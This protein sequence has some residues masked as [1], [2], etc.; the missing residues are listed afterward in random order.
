[1]NLI[2]LLA[3]L[4]QDTTQLDR[5]EAMLCE[6]REAITGKAC[7][8]QPAPP[9]TGVPF[10]ERCAADGVIYCEPFE[11]DT[12][13]FWYEADGTRH[14]WSNPGIPAEI[15]W[16]RKSR[17][18][19]CKWCDRDPLIGPDGTEY[20]AVPPTADPDVVASEESTASLRMTYQPMA[21]Q[22]GAGAYFSE[23]SEDL[24]QVIAPM[25]ERSVAERQEFRE[26]HPEL[27]LVEPRSDRYFMQYRIRFSRGFIYDEDGHRIT[28]LQENGKPTS[29]K[30]AIALSTGSWGAGRGG[31]DFGITHPRDWG[32]DPGSFPFRN[33]SICTMH[34]I[35]GNVTWNWV[36][37]YY[38]S[39]KSFSGMR[40][41]EDYDVGGSA[42]LNYQ[43]RVEGGALRFPDPSIKRQMDQDFVSPNAIRWE[44]DV[45]YTV[46]TGVEYGRWQRR[47]DADYETSEPES[48]FRLW[49][50]VDGG[51]QELVHET[52][53][54][55][56]DMETFKHRGEVYDD[57]RAVG[58]FGLLP[59]MTH[60]DPSIVYWLGH[61][62][63]D[64]VIVST[65]FI[66]DPK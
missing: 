37:K 50:G 44:P 31:G 54:K 40:T 9:E 56:E 38:H 16:A 62:W 43:N 41:R 63:Y 4:A 46:Q 10:S 13:P 22:N 33:S 21:W 5:I 1:M 34:E 17:G 51:P 60:R 64:E 26:Q 27:T 32:K 24:S 66:E 11:P 15:G 36:V 28:Y 45:W 3:L 52:W 30:H 2:A 19:E 47:T 39:C 61:V 48:R 55:A 35:V 59:F 23:I 58:R 57:L 7:A 65:E 18:I 53:F 20:Q 6:V 14:E 8:E 49:I 42:Q 25:D 29:P 12:G